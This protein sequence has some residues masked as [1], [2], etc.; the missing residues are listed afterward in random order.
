VNRRIV[1]QS[2]EACIW[3]I[4]HGMADR[5]YGRVGMARS[6]SGFYRCRYAAIAAF[7]V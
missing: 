5:R 4:D 2:A 6:T 7:F 3:L 1:V